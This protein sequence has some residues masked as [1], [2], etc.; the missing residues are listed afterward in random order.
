MDKTWQKSDSSS[1]YEYVLLYVDDF[2]VI[3]EN[4]EG[5]LVNEIGK[6][7]EL[8]PDSVG[9]PKLYFFSHVRKVEPALGYT[10]LGVEHIHSCKEWVCR[11]R[12]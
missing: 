7:F 12:V 6:Y 5:I 2:L 9:P 1:Y 3:S 11:Y 4:V 10:I 8:K